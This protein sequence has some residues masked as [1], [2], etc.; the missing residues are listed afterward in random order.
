MPVRSLRSRPLKQPSHFGVKV[1]TIGA[2][3][4]GIAPIIVK[5]RFGRD[6]RKKIEVSID[7]DTLREIASITGGQ[8]FR[9]TDLNEL[10]KI[11]DEIDELEKTD[12]V[13]QGFSV[14]KE[15]FPSLILA[16]IA[17]IFL[18]ILLANTR[19]LKLP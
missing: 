12:R 6:V 15:W 9:A 3:T 18:E 7:E 16:A 19:L 10:R 1:Y 13:L 8:Y 5:D 11:Y 4:K 14:E 2:G 17:L